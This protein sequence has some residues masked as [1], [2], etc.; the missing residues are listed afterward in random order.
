MPND[1]QSDLMAQARI[2]SDTL[3][4]QIYVDACDMYIFK[5]LLTKD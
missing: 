5:K 1:C 3:S 4:D 2:L